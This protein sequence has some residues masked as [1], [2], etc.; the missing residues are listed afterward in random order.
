LNLDKFVRNV[1][2]LP[3]VC[4]V[5]TGAGYY[6]FTSFAGSIGLGAFYFCGSI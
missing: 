4:Q 1:T 5:G 2:L 3:P 6:T